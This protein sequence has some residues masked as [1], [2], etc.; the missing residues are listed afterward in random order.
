MKIWDL[1]ICREHRFVEGEGP[2]DADI[3]LVGQNPGVKE[4]RTGRPFVG[5]AGQYLDK[6]LEQSGMKRNRIYVTSIVK[7]K[8]PDNRKPTR[9]EIRISIPYLVNQ[10]NHI[11]PELVVLMGTV[12]WNT[13][14]SKDITYIETY[15]PA[16]AMRFPKIQKKFE[17]DF[18][19]I[20]E[21]YEKKNQER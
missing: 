11:A 7:C 17:D 13:P 2:L 12:A 20:G 9:H 14:R 21:V 6:V 3:M 19:K 8:T 4:N 15:H 10:I 1:Q 18:K 5:R 16:A